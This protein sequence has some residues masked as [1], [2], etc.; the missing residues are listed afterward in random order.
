[1]TVEEASADDSRGPAGGAVEPAAAPLRVFLNYR[2]DDTGPAALLLY[3]RL[4]ARFGAANVFLD[5]KSVGLGTRWLDEIKSHGA[6]GGVLLA[7]IGPHWLASV[8]DR[9][10]SADGQAAQVEDY[11][12]ME[13]EFALGRWPGTVIP[14]LVGGARM[15]DA[16]SL[17]RPIR[18]IAGWEAAQ[19]RL[20]SFDED[21][22]QLLAKIELLTPAHEPARAPAGDLA[23]AGASGVAASATERFAR[24]A[25]A[26][27]A[28]AAAIPS[29]DDAH[30]DLVMDCMVGEGTVVPLLGSTVHG[31]LPDS[32]QLAA[33]LASTFGLEAGLGLAAVAQ[34]VAMARGPSFLHRAITDAFRLEP[35]INDVHRFLA[36]LPKRLEREGLPARYQLIVSTNYDATLERA[37]D[38]EGEAYDLAVFVAGGVDKGRFVHIPW[39]SEPRVIAQPS[40]YRDFPIDPFDELERTVIVKVYGAAGAIEGDA[41]WGRSYVMTEDQ[42]IDYLVTEQVATVVPLQV[43]NKLTSSHCLFMGYAMR[44]WSPRVFLKRIW[45]GRPLE[46]KSWAIERH[47]DALEKDLWG[48]LNVELLAA[49]PDEYVRRL[50]A[51]LTARCASGP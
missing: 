9:Q 13:L 41:R 42:Y 46:D 22:A 51:R 2:Q 43:L 7:L 17:P 11:V 29:P 44:D 6:Q 34:R 35:E 4:A 37:F 10:W 15:P 48:S 3:E 38:A 31:S 28:A 5:V 19:L 36:R 14:V 25:G 18:A 45:Q 21:F 33:Q 24:S 23:G 1:M 16:V 47:P 20:M 12:V 50:D 49:A 26:G 32:E 27:R 40:T 8:K 39:R 30:L